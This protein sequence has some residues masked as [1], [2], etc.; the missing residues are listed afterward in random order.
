MTDVVSTQ[1]TATVTVITPSSATVNVSGAASATVNQNQAVVTSAL[2]QVD[3]IGDP[4][5]IQFNT[6]GTPTPGVGRM[7]WKD[8]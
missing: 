1:S 2:T 3:S 8:T 5:W 7:N 6:T 4:S